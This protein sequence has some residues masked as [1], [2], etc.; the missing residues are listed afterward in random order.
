[1]RT[2]PISLSD[3]RGH[4]RSSV[5]RFEN[6]RSSAIGRPGDEERAR[7][8]RLPA[9]SAPRKSGA[10]PSLPPTRLACRGPCRRPVIAGQ[11]LF[12]RR[13]QT[14]PIFAG[15][16]DTYLRRVRRHLSSPG[17]G[18]DPSRLES[19]ACEH[20]APSLLTGFGF[21]RINLGTQPAGPINPGRITR[22]ILVSP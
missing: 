11:R 5:S 21:S 2:G 14:T 22:R 17:N 15:L 12:R 3:G 19:E 9:A 13:C 8:S 16:G 18:A 20:G 1:M 4:V 10:Y 6:S 7:D